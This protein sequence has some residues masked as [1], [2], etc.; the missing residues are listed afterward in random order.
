MKTRLLSA[1]ALALFL[2]AGVSGCIEIRGPTGP[3]AEEEQ[4]PSDPDPAA[5]LDSQQVPAGFGG[6]TFV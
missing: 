4:G 6:L 2:G 3:D 1:F 5:Y